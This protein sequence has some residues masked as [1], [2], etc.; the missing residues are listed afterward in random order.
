MRATHAD[1]NLVAA[2]LNVEIGAVWPER[3]D[4]HCHAPTMTLYTPL[5]EGR[6]PALAKLA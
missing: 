1:N 3:D 6:Y 4:R 5:V 2:N